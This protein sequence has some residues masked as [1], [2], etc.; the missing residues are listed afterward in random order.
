MNNSLTQHEDFRHL[1]RRLTFLRLA[2]LIG[3]FLL[4]SRVWYLQ[5]IKGGYYRDLSE[6]NRVRTVPI[7]SA[8]GLIFD[9]RGELLANNI[10]SFNL[11]ATVEDTKDLNGLAV[12][13][14]Q[15]IGLPQA[16]TKKRF[17]RHSRTYLPILLKSGLTLREAAVVEAH[18]LDLSGLRIQAESQRNYLHG[19]LASHLLGYVGEISQEQQDET[20]FTDLTMGTIVGKSGVEKSFDQVIRGRPGQ[21]TIEVDARGAERKTLAVVEQTS[22]DDLYLSIDLPMQRLAESLL[23][24]ESGAVVAIDPANGDVLVLASRPGY[25]PNIISHG[26]SSAVWEQ[27]SNDARHPLTNRAIQGVYPPGSTF[28]IMMASAALESA[29][30]TSNTKI[31]CSGSYPF[32]NH[33]FRDWKKG[34]HGSVDMYQGI[35][36]SCDV[37]FYML[38]NRIGIDAIA[39]AAHEYGLGKL[40]GIDLQGERSGIIPS[41]EWKQRARKEPW[42]PGE[43][44][45][46]SIGQGY[47]SVTPLQM[48]AAMA[49]VANGGVLYKPRLVRSIRERVTGQSRDI[50][51]AEKG[52]ISLDS[53]SFA[54]LHQALRGVVHEGTG[55][56]ADSKLVEISGKTGTA[57]SVG[58]RLQK[59][60]GE[61][62]PK[63]FRDHAWFVAYA[64]ADHPKIA[65]AVIVENIGHGGTFGAPIAKALIEEY[66]KDTEPHDRKPHPG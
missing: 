56:R 18:R 5:V 25:D 58:A 9:R 19:L 1:Q 38:G 29:K 35:V 32:G 11:Y 45:S 62:V 33:V 46:A 8:R 37:Y 28:K 43:T 24:P 60:E 20:A 52:V 17:A 39:D 22:G 50:L 31:H 12:S 55:K 10:P 21:K 57:Q 36:N 34:G 6:Q 59:S 49:A 26:P 65:V 15:L 30:W 14:E 44:I 51:P 66:L 63:Q 47:V 3:V 23:D 27:I 64:P 7:R 40:T 42:Y 13:L 54:F 48:A 41:T 2:L 61:D 53:D 16:E 4:F